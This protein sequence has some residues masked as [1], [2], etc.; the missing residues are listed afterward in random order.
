[1][2]VSDGLSLWPLNKK[3]PSDKSKEINEIRLIYLRQAGAGVSTFFQY[4]ERV[5]KVSQGHTLHLSG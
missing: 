2:F 3:I 4:F 5:A 1:M